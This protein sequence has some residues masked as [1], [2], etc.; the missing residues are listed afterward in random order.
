[1][2]N[3]EGPLCEPCNIR[4][5]SDVAYEAHMSI[6]PKHTF[7]ELPGRRNEPAVKRTKQQSKAQLVECEQC[8]TKLKGFKLYNYHFKRFHPDQNKTQF[9][10]QFPK[11]LL[12]ELC[13]KSFKVAC[14][15]RDHMQTAHSTR[16][17]Y[18]CDICN[19]KYSLKGI[20]ISHLKTHTGPQPSF[21]CP[22]C[23][24]MFSNKPN[25]K[26]HKLTHK[27]LKPY[28][29]HSCDKTFVNTSERSTHVLHSHLKQPWP[30]KN[31]GPRV[32]AS[33]SRHT[34]EA[35][36]GIILPK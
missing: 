31:R 18:Q 21:G 7:S 20:L 25:M 17:G 9:P 30:K 6:S 4:F 16:K 10:P 3:P 19:K 22:I 15:L 33:R 36:C 27:L 28:K 29:C 32:R 8:G 12:C 24:K 23:G 13:G 11:P 14:F 26:R 2:S 5:A 35:V 34:K 1:M